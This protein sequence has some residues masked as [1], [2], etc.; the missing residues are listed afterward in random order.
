MRPSFDAVLHVQLFR[1]EFETPKTHFF[2]CNAS[3]TMA[4]PDSS[5][6]VRLVA[7]SFARLR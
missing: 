3:L 2:S 5:A 4:N 6:E 1:K 7:F